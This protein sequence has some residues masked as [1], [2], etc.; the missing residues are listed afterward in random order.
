[1]HLSENELTRFP[2]ISQSP[3][4][5]VRATSEET[6][7]D[8]PAPGIASSRARFSYSRAPSNLSSLPVDGH[9]PLPSK[10]YAVIRYRGARVEL[11]RALLSCRAFTLPLCVHSRNGA[12]SGCAARMHVCAC[13]RSLLRWYGASSSAALSAIPR[14]VFAR[15]FASDSRSHDYVEFRQV[16]GTTAACVRR[17]TGESRLLRRRARRRS[18]RGS[19]STGRPERRT[20]RTTRSSSASRSFHVSSRICC[21][22]RLASERASKT[23]IMRHALFLRTSTWRRCRVVRRFDIRR[24]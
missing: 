7:I 12:T 6:K 22:T 14:N 5:H 15:A 1:M 24:V 2:S 9:S 16:F 8:W 11:K 20:R 3:R 19:R 17:I 18:A 4:G 10:G 23:R 13:A 21:L